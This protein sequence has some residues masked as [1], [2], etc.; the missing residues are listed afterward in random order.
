MTQT[1]SNE[2]IYRSFL[3]GAKYVINEK[4]QLNAIN[5]F[6]V[7]DGDTGSNLASLMKSILLKS[8]L[9]GSLEETLKSISRAALV[10]ARGNSGIIFASY[11]FGFSSGIDQNEIDID[12]L[13]K[14]L[15]KAQKSAYQAI[16]TPVE[17]T[18]IT[19]MRYFFNRLNEL[20]E[21]I[22]DIQ[23][24]LKQ[25]YKDLALALEQ[26]KDQLA[27]LKTSKVVDAGAK[28][29]YHFLEGFIKAM[30][31]EEINIDIK[32]TVDEIV[33]VD[34]FELGQTRY[35]TEVLIEGKDLKQEKIKHLLHPF[36]DSVV[37]A[38]SDEIRRVHIHTNT[39]EKVFER[40]EPVGKII[41]QK[42]DDMKRQF[43]VSNHK[44]HDIA[45]VTDSIADL[46]IEYIE[47]NQIHVLNLSLLINDVTYFDKLTIENSRFYQLMNHLKEY[48]KSSQPNPKTIEN[49]YS[50]LTSYYKQIIV[51][52][53]SSKMSGTYQAFLNGKKNFKDAQITVI[54]SIQNSVAQG[55]L[56]K[57]ASCYIN[58]GCDYETII[59]K[60]EHDKKRL[61][62]LV[63]VKT[64]KYMIRSGRLKRTTGL[65]GNLINLKPIISIDDEGM[66]IIFD[67]AF[68]ISSSDQK[69][70]NHIK[71][72]IRTEGIESYALVHI[73]ALDRL[74]YYEQEL[75]NITGMKPDYVT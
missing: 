7:A 62:I 54:D 53:V 13:I 49:L 68:S 56:V 58:Q 74:A 3:L 6:P 43:E 11:I 52:T 72:V 9:E 35:C 31:G 64:L 22:K 30:D 60:I 63:S 28:G 26:T 12:T 23:I 46:P 14:Q 37:V 15:D 32:D 27:I 42:V 36:G 65:V 73:N 20:K 5:V 41:D 47:D 16:E 8:S 59:D 39:P 69:I 34:H 17:G 57:K 33:H 25:A 66:G 38:G 55:M 1:L 50:F 19:L 10:G 67:K 4:D 70:F 44:K 29:Y 51:I 75:T 2:Q 21:S 48:P 61:K 40:L 71:E 45:L 18:M 24:L